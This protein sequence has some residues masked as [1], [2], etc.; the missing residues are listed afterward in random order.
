MNEIPLRGENTEA[1]RVTRLDWWRETTGKPLASLDRSGLDP[2]SLAGNIE[3]LVAGVEI[4]VGLAGPLLFRGERAVGLVTAPLATTE[5]AL[6]ASVARGARAISRS[7]GVETRVLFQR[8]VRAP[9]FEFESVGAAARFVQWVV[10]QRVE[11]ER[12][13]ATVSSHSKLVELDPVQIGRVI[14]LRFIYETADAG[15]QNMTTAST[16]RACQWINDEL[17]VMPGMRPTWFVIEANMSGDKKLTQLNTSSGRG[18]RVAAEAVLDRATIQ[19]VLKTTPEAIDRTCRIASAGSLASGAVGFDID[20]ANVIA[21][22]FV[23][24]GQDIASVYESGSAIFSAEP[25]GDGLRVSLLLPNL[26]IGTVG[27]GTGLQQQRDYLTALGCAGND[28]VKRLAEIICGF[29][30]ALDI[31]TLAAVAS[32]QFADAHERLGRGHRVNWLSAAD[33][34]VPLLEPMLAEAMD[35]PGLTVT[36]V[37]R[38]EED[39]RSS[40]LS[41][42]TARGDNRKLIGLFP[43]RLTYTRGGDAKEV[44]LVAKVKPLDQEVIIEAA[45]LASL[46]GGRLAEIYPRWRDWTGFKDT[47]TRE[48]AIYRSTDPVLRGVLPEVYGIHEDPTREASII[49]MERLG[50]EVILKDSAGQPELWLEEYVEAAIRGIG[51]VHR[52]WLGRSEMATG[53]GTHGAREP[54]WLGRVQSATRMVAMGELWE[55]LTEHNAVEHPAWIG[56]SEHRRLNE[57]IATL[58]AWWEELESMPWTLVHGDF[59]PRNIALRSGS[60]QLV[61][62]DWELATLHVP[63][64]DLVELLT[65]VLP[66]SSDK[67][68]VTRY[69]ELHRQ[70]VAPS[71]GP[72]AW[73]RGYQLA[74]WD[75]A[76]NRVQLY[77][78]AHTH[79]EL[80]FLAHVVPTLF[81]LIALEDQ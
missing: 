54:G 78:M 64:R 4:P 69:V 51:A 2:R 63:Q 50:P 24:T 76:I 44:E 14:H 38:L 36:D 10:R 71:M 48:P 52:R 19:Q 25:D 42:L 18:S 17:A 62:Y 32:G 35:E 33:L 81:H 55:A 61:A 1:A 37:V 47:H 16:W 67:S 80:P 60:L 56:V 8:M 58:P 73:R 70:I 3:N 79:R 11:L 34:D 5:G 49:L 46:C 21:A 23:A 31:S 53:S 7:G 15:G 72:A 68:L 28:G 27:G 59:N 6:V 12:E 22:M 57:L 26:V 66:A 45:K 39:T 20:A 65:Y 30:L 9:G 41:D 77:L 13:I 75:F 74:L 43:L 29:S 40:I